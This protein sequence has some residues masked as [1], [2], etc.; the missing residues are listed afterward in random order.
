M[1]CIKIKYFTILALKRNTNINV[2]TF[3]YGRTNTDRY[4]HTHTLIYNIKYE[5]ISVR[6]TFSLKL[7]CC[8]CIV[9]VIWPWL[10]NDYVI[11]MRAFYI[12]YIAFFNSSN[13]SHLEWFC[14]DVILFGAYFCYLLVFIHIRMSTTTSPHKTY[15][16]MSK[17][18]IYNSYRYTTQN[19][20][21]LYTITI[22]ALIKL[23][24]PSSPIVY[25][26]LW[27]RHLRFY[28]IVFCFYFAAELKWKWDHR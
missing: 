23:R 20:R 18:F 13:I 2:Q 27:I 6:E 14:A 11:H 4:A 28:C 3:A 19:N 7:T 26:W 17:T 15:Y 5:R 24:Q 12:L 10:S 1:H 8:L 21:I 25:M 9:S 22:L 16:N